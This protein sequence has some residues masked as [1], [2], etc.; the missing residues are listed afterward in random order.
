MAVL[1][2]IQRAERPVN[3]YAVVVVVL[4]IWTGA[5][6]PPEG[7]INIRIKPPTQTTRGDHV[8][9]RD[10]HADGPFLFR[11]DMDKSELPCYH[12][13]IRIRVLQVQ[14]GFIQAG[15]FPHSRKYPGRD[16][17]S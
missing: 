6:P 2:S 9:Q 1:S 14:N 17:V 5:P 15:L 12:A 4:V 7:I 16:L 11:T 3:H 10:L 13:R 8:M